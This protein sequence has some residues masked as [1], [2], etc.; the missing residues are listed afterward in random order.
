[1]TARSSNPLSSVLYG[2]G[3]VFV[4]TGQRVVGSGKA[5]TLF[6]VLG[7]LLVVAAGGLLFAHRLR[8]RAPADRGPEKG[9]AAI[10]L[11]GAGALVAYFLSSD[12]VYHLTG[13]TM[14]KMAPRLNAVLE[15]LWPALMVLGTLPVLF[16]EL[17][18]A[19]MAR[20]PVRDTNRVRAALMSGVGIGFALVFSFAFAFVASDR[21]VKVDLS[22]FRV[23]RAGESTLKVAAALD[24]PIQIALFFPPANEVREEVESYFDELKKQSPHVKVE[25]FDHA[26]H[27]AKAKELGVSGNGIIVIGRDNLRE[28]LGLPLKLE[29]ARDQLKRLDE[30]VQK[31][32]LGV[33]RPPRVAYVTQGHEERGSSSVEDTDRRGTVRLIRDFLLDQ[34]YEVKDLGMAEGLANEVPRDATLVLVIGPRKPFSPEEAASIEKFVDRKGRVLIALD[35]ESGLAMDELLKPV[36]L[37]FRPTMLAHDQIYFSRTRQIADRYNLITG[38]YSSHVSVTT[39]SKYG[40]RAPVLFPTAGYLEQTGDGAG[41]LTSVRF[42]IHSDSKAW[43]DTNGNYEFDSGN[44]VRKTYEVAAAV[45]KR[46]ASAVLPEEEGR[47]VVFADADVLTDQIVRS[48]GNGVMFV[49]AVR[50]LGGEERISGRVNNE[51]DSPITHTRKQDVAWFYGTVFVAPALVL[52]VGVMATRRRRRSRRKVAVESANQPKGQQDGQEASP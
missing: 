31:R 4:F 40:T 13:Y 5:G 16:V 2:A 27:P 38:S 44:E 28:Q 25:M 51:E 42:T 23:A 3:L 12:L 33:T 18:L 8:G 41:G 45:S 21:D 48:S 49:D 26:L 10:Y 36:G 29:R 20:A 15:T 34:G 35:P 22:Y 17:S 52:G 43:A 46:N 11:V 9:L 7:V 39:L 37:K 1:M 50:W 24:K 47:V 32:L 30:E 14:A 6:T 19:T